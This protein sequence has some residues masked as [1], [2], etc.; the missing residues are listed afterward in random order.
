MTMLGQENAFLLNSAALCGIKG[1]CDSIGANMY[2]IH[3]AIEMQGKDDID[4]MGRDLVHPGRLVQKEYAKLF[5]TT[6]PWT[7]THQNIGAAFTLPDPTHSPV[8]FP[9]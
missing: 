7:F 9:E 3:P 8:L 6:E 2:M 5:A 4:V 1:I